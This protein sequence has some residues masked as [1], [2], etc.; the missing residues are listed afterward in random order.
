MDPNSP[1]AGMSKP[2]S[3]KSGQIHVLYC[4]NCHYVWK[5]P[6]ETKKCVNCRGY[7]DDTVRSLVAYKSGIPIT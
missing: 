3:N 4:E 5:A 6:A 1:F 7:G 2:Q